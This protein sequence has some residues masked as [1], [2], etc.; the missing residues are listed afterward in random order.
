MAQQARNPGPRTAKSGQSSAGATPPDGRKTLDELVA[1]RNA[2][3]IPPP[4]VF[5]LE[6]TDPAAPSTERGKKRLAEL[7]E[8]ARHNARVAEEARALALE[9]RRHLEASAQRR[10]EVERALAG[11]Q[12][13]IN[14]IEEE[15]ERLIAQARF[16]AEHDVRQELEAAGPSARVGT[17]GN[18]APSPNAAELERLQAQLTAQEELSADHRDRLRAAVHE[19]DAAILEGRRA[20]SAREHLER[21]MEEVTEALRRATDES[22]DAAADADTR[23]VE[24]RAEIAQLRADLEAHS[25]DAERIASL[26]EELG[27]ERGRA[28]GAERRAGVLTA[29]LDGAW[30]EHGTVTDSLHAARCELDEAQLEIA[31]QRTRVAEL[32]AE[33]E[34]AAERYQQALAHTADVEMHVAELESRIADLDQA[35]RDGMAQTALLERTLEAT[36]EELVSAQGQLVASGEQSEQLGSSRDELA[37]RC[38]EMERALDGTREELVSAQAQLVASGEQSEHLAASLAAAEE[39]RDFA[40][41]RVAE[42]DGAVARVNE[43]GEAASSKTADLEAMLFEVRE[44]AAASEKELRRLRRA[45]AKAE[46][47]AESDA[48]AKAAIVEQHATTAAGLERDVAD[49]RAERDRLASES[50]QLTQALAAA[51]ADAEQLRLLVAERELEL[52]QEQEAHAKWMA[53]TAVDVAP[54]PQR[55][56]RRPADPQPGLVDVF[57]AELTELGVDQPVAAPVAPTPIDVEPAMASVAQ[58]TEAEPVADPDEREDARPSGGV[59]TRRAMLSQLSELASDAP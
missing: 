23:L 11:L 52:A 40:R 46:R 5:T 45:A 18:P 47:T 12:R 19:R 25:R 33:G 37:A 38:D 59:E 28:E 32:K 4:P 6:I 2:G 17:A 55:P 39:E 29:D 21:R 44:R 35:A 36:R 41:A 3:A 49:A 34:V 1:E 14:R 48:D 7:E 57:A 42:L 50:E 8:H 24:A 31:E 27:H 10:L 54:A 43:E 20:V 56:A 51:Q 30:A 15:Q 9:Q 13:E 53:D 16:R 26:E 22:R 58:P